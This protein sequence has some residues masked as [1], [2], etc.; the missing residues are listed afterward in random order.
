MVS[1][2]AVMD[3]STQVTCW[4]YLAERM[5]RLTAL[6]P[7]PTSIQVNVLARDRGWEGGQHQHPQLLGLRPG[8]EDRRPDMY[9]DVVE[10]PV[11]KDGLHGHASQP[12]LHKPV[13]GGDLLWDRVQLSRYLA[14]SSGSGTL[15]AESW[16]VTWY[17]TSTREED[18]VVVEQDSFWVEEIV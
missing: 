6:L 12:P 16:A 9:G 3:L 15:A 18:W 13:D 7:G 17:N 5:A 10:V 11:T 4:S 14:D 1:C 8:D 2:K